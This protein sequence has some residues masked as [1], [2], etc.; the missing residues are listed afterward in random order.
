[1]K[2]RYI[3]SLFVVAFFLLA[4]TP[5]LAAA[6]T[7]V[8][9]REDVAG[10]TATL[11]GEITAT[12]N[13][14]CIRRGFVWDTVSRADPGDIAPG[15]SAYANSWDEVGSFG[16]GIFDHGVVGLDEFTTYYYRAATESATLEWAY[17]EEMEFFVGEEGKVYF[18]LRPDLD[19]TYIR[20]QAGVPTDANVG[21]FNGYSLPI[22]N[23]DSEELHYI[24]CVP[25]RWD[26]ESQILIHVDYCLSSANQSDTSNM[27]ELLWEHFTPNVDIVPATTNEVNVGRYFTSED[28]YQSYQ[29]WF[30]VDYDIDAGDPILEDDL[31]AVC[32]RRETTQ[33]QGTD[34]DELIVFAIDVLFARGD[35][36]GDPE[37][38]ITEADMVD[39]GIS[40]FMLVLAILALGLTIAMFSTRE[41]ML[42]FPCA[43]FWAVLGGFAYT[44]FT[45]AWVDWQFYLAFACLLGMVP[46][47]ALAAFGLREKRDTIADEDMGE[48]GKDEGGYVDE[49]KEAVFEE[50]SG[51]SERTK[52]IRDRAKRRRTETE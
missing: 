1:M 31:I 4:S 36:L 3:P 52:G 8:T 44:Q 39:V 17:G 2:K 33:P 48:E 28:Q 29:D 40:L 26:G 47:S 35:L 9:L 42:G 12:G 30:V 50:E 37:S 32:L 6:P 21:E 27:W 13:G 10:I 19:E 49:E 5:I 15:D 41:S 45:T 23:E 18:E 14:N 11:K 34:A 24:I 7:V 20:G 38:V 16:V 43:I 22:W 46:F 25:E 51:V